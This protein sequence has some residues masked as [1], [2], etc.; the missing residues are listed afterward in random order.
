MELPCPE[1]GTRDQL[2][3]RPDAGARSVMLACCR[4]ATTIMTWRTGA[5]GSEGQRETPGRLQGPLWPPGLRLA[6]VLEMRPLG[7]A[8]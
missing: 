4:E 7:G 5:R 6:A 2:S 1:P 8:G 3:E